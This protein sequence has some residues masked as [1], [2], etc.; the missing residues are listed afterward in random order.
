M[1]TFRAQRGIA[2]VEN[3]VALAMLGIALVGSVSLFSN[4]M[5]SNKASRSYM[6]LVS[7]VQDIVDQYREESFTTLIARFGSNIANIANGTQATETYRSS[8]SRATF[9]SRLTAIRSHG[10]GSP[11]AVRLEVT[12]VQRR[13]KLGDRTYTFETIIANVKR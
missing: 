11:E 10:E 8:R 2:L 4:S 5:N 3:L 1:R 12:A 9:T 6:A 13:N 7:E